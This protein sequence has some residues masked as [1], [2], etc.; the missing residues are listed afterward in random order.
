MRKSTLVSF[1]MKASLFLMFFCLIQKQSTGQTLLAG[2]DF[3]TTSGG[4]TA[5]AVSPNSPQVF[6]ANVGSGTMYLDGSNHSSTWVKA[7]S[8][9]ELTAF[10]GSNLNTSGTTLSTT[11]TSPASLAL[12]GGASTPTSNGKFII[13]K[14]SMTGYT[15]LVV[16]Y[17]TQGTAAGFSTQTWE[18]S[19]DGSSWSSVGSVTSIP[20][21]FAVKT[22]PTITGLDNATT[23]YLR[24]TG[25]GATSA[26]GNNRLDN[27]QLNATAA[28]VSHTVTF[29][30]NYGTPTTSTQSA[31]SATNLTA[32]SFTRT[33]YTF[34]GWT[35][36]NDGT[37][38][39]Y[40]DAASYTFAADITLY[41]KWT[42]NN[43]TVTF[44]ANGGT[45]SMS[46]QTIATA[47]SANLTSNAFTRAGYTFA[48]WATTAGGTVAY[49]DGASYTMGTGNVTLYAK[50]TANNNTITF[51]ANGG[52]GSMSNQTIAT[53]A[54]ANLIANTFAYSGNIFTG[55][56]TT[57][58]GTVAYADGA[59]YTMGTGNVTLYA[60][61]SA[62]S[63]QTIT[64][65]ALSAVTYGDAAFS[66]GATASSGLTVSYVSSDP[67][68]ASVSGNTVTILKAGSVT[69]TASQAGNSSYSAATSVGQ[70]LTI[71]TKALTVTGLSVVT[72][73]YNSTT[74]ATLTGTP[75]LS[76]I[77]GS[78]D[79]SL[80]GTA[81]ASFASANYSA[82]PI[83][84][85]VTGYTLGGTNAS[86]Y[87]IT[88]PTLSGTI[89]K[90]AAYSITSS[91]D[92]KSY[93]TT[94]TL[95]AFTTA[96]LFGTDA[97]T[98]VTLTSAGAASTA[99]VSGSPYTISITPGS[100]LGS[101]LSNYNTPTYNNTGTLTVNKAT[102]TITANNLTRA[103]NAYVDYSFA[104]TEF[105]ASGLITA[106]GDVVSGVTLTSTGT[107]KTTAI[108]TYPIVAAT[109]V[110]TG[111]GNYNIS[112]VNGTMTVTNVLAD[113]T[114]EGVSVT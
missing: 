9:N 26:S 87:S 89:N 19:T 39:S 29:N 78:D 93:G 15:N 80:S 1:L 59:S 42:A 13:F 54:T 52:T 76:G 21:S 2:W 5:A 107:P 71:N 81:S 34:A 105:I 14:F 56:A 6:V 17:A 97:V 92:S 51:D 41:A 104:G 38:T 73:T 48:G 7:S 37:G 50:W 113:W 62:L 12:L 79:V 30:S 86:N 20:T 90:A 8:G 95:S 75:A 22:L 68:I 28:S 74:A 40:A 72:K 106:N 91:N 16:S 60:K 102:L 64:F 83:T 112:Y 111:L 35:T 46:N 10:A 85:N 47:A 69:I 66:L 98:S 61:W 100:E 58:G 24:F 94:K 11:T 63:P 67:T 49:S 82:T 110:G 36:V 31:S 23:A 99:V 43:N 3:Q 84:V 108:G 33:G 65:G 44:N 27:I 96:G 103:L 25:T 88:Q 4:G 70:T 101:G 77:V 109:A 55:W 53:A 32:N 114:F 18:Y 57:A 45:G